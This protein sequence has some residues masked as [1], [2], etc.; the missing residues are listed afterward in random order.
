MKNLKTCLAVMLVVIMIMNITVFA[1]V[2]T[3]SNK[4]AYADQVRLLEA[5]GVLDSTQRNEISSVLTRA[6]FAKLLGRLIGYSDAVN[7]GAENSV[8]IDV[9]KDTSEI[10]YINIVTQL[11]YME[12]Y[13]DKTFRPDEAITYDQAVKSLVCVLGYE[14]KAKKNG[15]Y[16]VGYVMTAQELGITKNVEGYVNYPLTYGNLTK[17]LIASLEVDIMKQTGFNE[18]RQNYNSEKGKNIL[19]EYLKLEKRKGIV[20]TTEL[21]DLIKQETLQNNK[22]KVGNDIY[23][24]ERDYTSLLGYTIEFYFK[25]ENDE[26][27]IAFIKDTAKLNDVKR[28]TADDIKS[29]KDRTYVYYNESNKSSTSEVKIPF[30]CYVIYNGKALSKYT[31]DDLFPESGNITLIDNN[32]DGDYDV[33]YIMDYEQ[34]VV[35]SVDKNNEIITDKYDK[36]KQLDL[37]YSSNWNRIIIK[38]KSGSDVKFSTLK[39]WDVLSVAKSNDG[40]IVTIIVSRESVKGEIREVNT[41]ENDTCKSITIGD[42][43]YDVPNYYFE[44]NKFS[45]G[46]AGLFYL[47]MDGKIIAFKE[48]VSDEINYGFILEAMLP[49]NGGIEKKMEFRIFDS[50]NKMLYLKGAERINIDNLKKQDPLQVIE[51]LKQGTNVVKNNKTYILPQVIEYKLNY[52]NEVYEINTPYNVYNKADYM[53]VKPKNGEDEKSLRLLYST[54][55]EV[56]NENHL[57]YFTEQLSF[58]GMVNISS[59]TKMFSMPRQTVEELQIQIDELEDSDFRMLSAGHYGSD[60]WVRIDG[61]STGEDDLISDVTVSWGLGTEEDCGIVSKISSVINDDGMEVKKV[62]VESYPDKKEFIVENESLIAGVGI[63]DTVEYSLRYN[64]TLKSI[65]KLFDAQTSGISSGVNN[66]PYYRSGNRYISG[67]VYDRKDNLFSISLTHLTNDDSIPVYRALE[68]FMINDCRIFSFEKGAKSDKLKPA[69]KEEIYDY[70]HNGNNQSRVFIW[71]K[72]ANPRV[73]VIYK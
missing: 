22:I 16:P 59:S 4:E 17:M 68:K 11:G 30:G 20:E 14:V 1:S 27:T 23:N 44:I 46:K 47:N 39:E 2:Y 29:Y 15:G 18:T 33:I 58:S 5:V 24:V 13:S 3:K 38:D 6:D 7:N 42:V 67:Y 12:G 54:N 26:N 52:K 66:N 64:K 56:R 53:T 73:I 34:Y 9:T 8:F 57:V 21:S 69:T 65:I 10:G 61:Y 31:D 19:T 40:R 41:R 48:G 43:E 55:Y 71:C 62:V 72:N 50:S 25:T 70:K 49:Q 45:L 32:R 60:D 35:Q 37:D 28:I 51:I 36:T 63:G